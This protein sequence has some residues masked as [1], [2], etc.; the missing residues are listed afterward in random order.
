MLYAWVYAQRNATRSPEV[1]IQ[2]GLI[3]RKEIFKDD[4][5]YGLYLGKHRIDDATPYL[6]EFEKHLLTLLHELFNPT[7]PFDQ[8]DDLKVCGFCDYREI[9][10]R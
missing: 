10:S 6:P 7:V 5:E 3:N 9:C 1:K 8:T 2:P 4:F